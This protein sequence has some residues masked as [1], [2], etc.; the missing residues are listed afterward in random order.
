MSTRFLLY[1]GLIAA[2][3]VALAFPF[4]FKDKNESINQTLNLSASIISSIATV[5]TVI[6]ALI[7]FNKF[8]VETPLIERSSS[9]V[10]ELLEKIKETNFSIQSDRFYFWINMSNP[11]KYQFTEQYY[12]EK[13]SFSI[14]YFDNLEKLFD[15]S[16]N[17]FIPPINI[18]KRG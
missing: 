10:F 2:I 4:I 6:I 8:G 14:A 7:L 1:L 3:I 16:S 12:R 17:P 15:I 11:F 13:F 9:K 18:S 5:L